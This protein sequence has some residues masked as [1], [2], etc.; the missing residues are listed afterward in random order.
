MIPK[1]K[2]YRELLVNKD[3]V[4]IYNKNYKIFYHSYYNGYN[5]EKLKIP[6]METYHNNYNIDFSQYDILECY[7]YYGFIIKKLYNGENYIYSLNHKEN[8]ISHIKIKNKTLI[9]HYCLPRFQRQGYIFLLIYF[10]SKKTKL[11]MEKISDNIDNNNLSYN[12]IKSGLSMEIVQISDNILELSSDK[13]NRILEFDWYIRSLT[14]PRLSLYGP[15]L[16]RENYN[17]FW[18]S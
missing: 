1:I 15:K 6:Y 2:N 7:M 9:E 11:K 3:L 5:I 12:I 18:Y 17:K 10:I 16:F 14:S 8:Y 13:S 4:P